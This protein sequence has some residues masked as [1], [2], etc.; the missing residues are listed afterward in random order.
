MIVRIKKYQIVGLI[1]TSRHVEIGRIH[2][3]PFVNVFDNKQIK[4][5]LI[6]YRQGRMLIPLKTYKNVLKTM[7]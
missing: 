6:C 7:H 4:F 3:F 5:N 1:L 2:A